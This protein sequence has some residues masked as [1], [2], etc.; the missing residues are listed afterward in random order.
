[1]DVRVNGKPRALPDGSSVKDL[2]EVLGLRTGHVVVEL[3]G[4]PVERSR[5]AAIELGSGDVVE[6]VRAVPGG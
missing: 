1:M 3:N 2:I 5:Y 4:T 6:V